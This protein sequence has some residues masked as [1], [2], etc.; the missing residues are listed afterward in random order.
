MQAMSLE[1]TSNNPTSSISKKQSQ[2]V[3]IAPEKVLGNIIVVTINPEMDQFASLKKV[4]AKTE[5]A[6]KMFSDYR[7]GL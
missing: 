7:K 1:K 3:G 4:S 6:K 2:N 5:A